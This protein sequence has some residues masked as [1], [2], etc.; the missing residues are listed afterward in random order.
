[1][2]PVIA[3]R[4]GEQFEALRAMKYPDDHEVG[5]TLDIGEFNRKFRQYFEHTVRLMLRAQ[6][7]GNLLGVL[8]GTLNVPDG[9]DCEDIV[10]VRVSLAVNT[11]SSFCW[12][13]IKTLAFT[14]HKMTDVAASS[15]KAGQVVP[16]WSR[17]KPNGNGGKKPP[18]PPSAPTMP[19]T[20][21]V[22]SGKYCS[23]A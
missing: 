7:F 10:R 12:S 8:V 15:P 22:S 3:R 13:G 11:S 17:K 4:Y 1:M 9:L 19:V 16:V 14:H 23:T 2:W 21:P 5:K 18:S 6:S 20:V